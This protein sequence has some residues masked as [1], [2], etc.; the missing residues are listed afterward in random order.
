MIFF[1]GA[2]VFPPFIG[3]TDLVRQKNCV[4]KAI[5]DMGVSILQW[6]SEAFKSS[7]HK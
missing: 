4:A 2:S 1:F 5:A 6:V 7:P 3:G